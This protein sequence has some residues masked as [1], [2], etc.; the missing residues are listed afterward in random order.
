LEI[1]VACAVSLLLLLATVFVQYEVLSAASNLAE[2]MD[3]GRR[4]IL[5]IVAAIAVAH[6]L[7]I[8]LYT[9]A[10]LLLR[11]Q[12][13]MGDIAGDFDGHIVLDYF[14]FSV[15][16]YTTLGIGDLAPNGPLRIIAGMQSLNGFVLLGWSASAA[17][18]SMQKTWDRNK[19]NG[20]D[21]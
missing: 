19:G 13:G 8:G 10:Y 15:A 2:R 16:T 17:F 21:L 4:S 6:L 14:Y 7:A 11:A 5:V 18:L 12:E 3:G 1:F 20:N 9:G